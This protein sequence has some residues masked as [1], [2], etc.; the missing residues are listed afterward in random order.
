MRDN[1]GKN[2]AEIFEAR[3]WHDDHIMMAVGFFDDAQEPA[4]VVFL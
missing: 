1:F 4:A 3:C 2:L